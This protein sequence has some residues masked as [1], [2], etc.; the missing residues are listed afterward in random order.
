MNVVIKLFY[1]LI[2]RPWLKL[3]IGVQFKNRTQLKDLD[4]FIIVANHNS[5]F[6]SLSIMAA[7]PINKLKKIKA[8]AAGD[9]FGK[10]K[11]TRNL[12]KW[13]FNAILI[14]RNRKAGEPSII[15]VL[16]TT[17]KEGNSLILY[18][19][20]SRGKPGVISDFKKGIAIL[21]KQNPN[22][23]FIPVYLDGFGRVLP[24]DKKLIVPLV[25]KVRFGT[26]IYNHEENID[27]I[28]AEVKKAILVLKDQDERDRNQFTFI[29]EKE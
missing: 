28:L 29:T 20:G 23:P 10:K 27:L 11:L 4:Q 26:P 15:E 19:E 16:D 6:D 5:H 8:V 18:P 9:Y 21:L 1:L 25:C 22:V 7:M 13:F 2:I 17:L 12:M 14:N 24:K 3:I